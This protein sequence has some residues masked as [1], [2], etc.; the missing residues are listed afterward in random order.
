MAREKSLAEKLYIDGFGV[1]FSDSRAAAFSDKLRMRRTEM[2]SGVCSFMH[3]YRGFG[4]CWICETH[5]IAEAHHV[6]SRWD[7]V[8]NI[9]MVCRE[10]HERIQHNNR[11]L[12]EV[13]RACWKHNRL[14]LS[15][16]H[17]VRARGKWFWFD[18]LDVDE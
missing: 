10:C 16:V 11:A 14:L 8:S 17:I 12:P 13:L 18:S 7:F 4:C 3:N 15:W 9:C 2:P 1:A 6:V 5:P